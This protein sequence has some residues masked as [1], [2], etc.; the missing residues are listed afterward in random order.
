ML[1][2]GLDPHKRV[3]LFEYDFAIDGGAIGTIALRGDRLPLGAVV[4]NGAIH[5]NT[6]VTSAGA[7]TTTLG[8]NT[9]VDVL[10]STLKAAQSLDAILDVVPVDTAATS[11]LTATAGKGVTMTIGTAAITAGKFTVALEYF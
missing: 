11:I 2:K 5:V 1:R 10:A 3:A 9:A 7:C 8:V 4:R 6:A